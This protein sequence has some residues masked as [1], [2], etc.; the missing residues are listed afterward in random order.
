[1]L[2]DGAMW[3]SLKRWP[4]LLALLVAFGALAVAL[5]YL[6]FGSRV[7]RENCERIQEGMT[8]AEVRAILG[9]PWGYSLLD[10]DGPSFPEAWDLFLRLGDATDQSRKEVP[11]ELWRKVDAWIGSKLIV[12]V[13]FDADSRVTYPGVLISDFDPPRTSLP[14]RVWRRLRARYG[15]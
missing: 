2:Y 9:K 15:W 14:A 11:H 4:V 6:P 12:F 8:E 7:T 1:V 3:K 5:V 10:P 13:C